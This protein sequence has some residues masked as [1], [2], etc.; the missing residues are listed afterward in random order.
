M[1]FRKGASRSKKLLLVFLLLSFGQLLASELATNLVV[2]RHSRNDVVAFWHHYYMASEGYEARWGGDVDFENCTLTPPSEEF[3][4]DVQR[5]VNYYRAMAGLPGNARFEE[6][7]V[8]REN[9]DLF[10]PAAGTTKLQAAVAAALSIG[11]QDYDSNN[12]ENFSLS[13]DLDD[14]F[15]CFNATAWNGAKNSNLAA[16]LWGPGAIDGYMFEFGTPSDPLSNKNV[17]HRR[18]ILFSAVGGMATAD[19]PPVVTQEAVIR[20]AINVHYVL[21]DFQ[22]RQLQFVAW[23]N[24]GFIPEPIVPEL[25]SLSYP[26]A[27]FSEAQVTMTGPDGQNISLNV[28]TRSLGIPRRDQPP[29]M[30]PAENVTPKNDDIHMPDGPGRG[31]YAD[32][33][34]VWIP[35]NLPSSFDE[36][37]TYQVTVTGIKEAPLTTVTYPVTIINPNVVD[38]L[39]LIGTDTPPIEG[40]NYYF[41][42]FP[43]YSEYEFEVSMRMPEIPVEDAEGVPAIIDGSLAGVDLVGAHS[44]SA[45]DPAFPDFYED[46]KSFRLAFKR[47]V[48]EPHWFEIDRSLTTSP[49]ATVNFR[50]R[51]GEM[52][53][54]TY[55]D[56]E[57][58]IDGGV[59]WQKTN[60]R[61]NGQNQAIDRQFFDSSANLPVADGVRVRFFQSWEQNQAVGFNYVD[62]APNRAAGI[63]I[64]QISFTNAETA[65]PPISFTLPAGGLQAPLTSEAFG[66]NLQAGRTYSLRARPRV[67]DFTFAWG[68]VKEVT[69]QPAS[70]L[71]GFER[72]TELTYPTAG[73]FNDDTDGDGLED[74]LEYALG[75]SPISGGDGLASLTLTQDGGQ[76]CF[77][78]PGG[79]LQ[80][81]LS[82]VAEYTTDLENWTSEGVMIETAGGQLKAFAPNDVQGNISMRWV[83]TQ[84]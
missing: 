2:N 21:G 29:L 26:G 44:F 27:D 62:L 50:Y 73:E 12:I 57:T 3:T 75:T 37:M 82:Y 16:N 71:V 35:Q 11:S 40:A 15:E 53:Q 14:S 84:Q 78:A 58:S 4:K 38:E 30:P 45:T 48:I 8:Y 5:R 81:G 39:E 43:A 18:W 49:G 51:R 7:E 47:L 61:I 66:Q 17:G 42:G 54:P 76:F 10:S 19:I 6:Q 33:T 20:P 63:F 77:A 46:G 36:D 34:I 23:P 41:G 80:P 25:W 83:I 28:V 70:P 13:H 22:Q 56:V 65:T 9:D 52:S 69:V 60:R 32:S 1:K 68:P 72:W 64:D 74:G 79:A 67:A 59:T 24:D 55:M 31:Y